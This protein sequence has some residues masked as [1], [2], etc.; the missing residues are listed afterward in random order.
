MDD[1]KQAALYGI[2]AYFEKWTKE[3]EKTKKV[4]ESNNLLPQ[5]LIL[6]CCYI[7]AFSKLRYP[8]KVNNEAFKSL[9]L[10]YSGEKE[11][12]SQIDLH[13]LYMIDK[14]LWADNRLLN[15]LKNRITI[16]KVLEDNF[17]GMGDYYSKS[18]Y[19]SSNDVLDAFRNS[20][21]A[22]I[23]MLNIEKNIE[24]YSL[25]SFLYHV[26]RCSAVHE[27]NFPGLNE[28]SQHLDDG[29]VINGHRPNDILTPEVIWDTLFNILTQ[30]KNECLVKCKFPD[31]LSL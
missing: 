5:W 2:E 22:G 17:E 16:K 31:R 28:Y 9:V 3:L 13:F 8:D 14:S 1:D 23:D 18:R 29:N 24:N 15:K 19:Q 26:I 11:F 12:Y 6:M 20:K 27:N 10:E 4:L 25:A 21:A 30:L 7:D